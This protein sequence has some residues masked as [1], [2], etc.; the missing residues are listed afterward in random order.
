MKKV[1]ID[2]NIKYYRANLHCHSTISDGRKTVEDLKRDYM[3]RGYSVIA[4]T[5]HDVYVNHDDL[6]DEN[7]IAL[8]SYELDVDESEAPER[9]AKKTCHL[10]YIALDKENDISLCFNK[11]KYI[12]G[13]ARQFIDSQHYIGSP[14]YERVYS[15]EGINDMIKFGTENG[16]YVTYNH[17]IW[18]CE[19]F[20]QF[21]EYK[22]M[23]A[24]EIV[25]YSSIVSGWDDDNSHFY[26][27]MLNLGNNVYCIATDDNHNRHDDENPMCDSYGGY[28]MI[29]AEKLEYSLITKSL[30]D[31]NFYCCVGD[32]KNDAPEIKSLVYEDGK[33]YIKTS[34]ARKITIKHN[35][36]CARSRNAENGKTVNDAVF[37]IDEN[38]KWFRLTVIDEKGFKAYTNAYFLDDI[39]GE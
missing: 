30:V 7:F 24:M 38:A 31:G 3:A 9:E 6:T 28:T 2:E 12:W 16:F 27:E 26:E 11:D 18:S 13:N 15:A 36:R 14:D 8:N 1:L 35:T 25:N 20:P 33:V 37:D 4:F 32:Y 34:D 21:S 29:G 23:N 39:K 10:C 5:D 17:P 19:S 22:G